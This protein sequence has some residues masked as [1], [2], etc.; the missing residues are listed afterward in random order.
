MRSMPRCVPF[1]RRRSRRSW[2]AGSARPRGRR[3]RG[4]RPGPIA[5]AGA[6]SRWPRSARLWSPWPGG[7][8]GWARHGGGAFSGKDPSKVD[9]SAAYYARYIAKHVVAAKLARRCEV[10]FAY[11]IGV[12]K[13]VSMLVQTFGTG[14]VSDDKLSAAVSRVFDARPGMRLLDI[15]AGWGAMTETA[16]KRG[17]DTTSLTISRR[18]EA[19]VRDLITAQG[20][21]ARVIRE[22]LLEYR[23]DRPYDAIVNLGVSEHLPDYAATLAC[24]ERLLVPGGKIY[25]DACSSRVR[26]RARRGEAAAPR[27]RRSRRNGTRSAWVSP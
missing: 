7:A 8:S 16:G 23:P 22:H 20:L 13:P 5:L 25:L 18:S 14:V 26:A 17:I 11:A 12:A 19:Y 15:G 2:N 10:Q 24:Y 27:G 4:A 1:R 21:P 6:C 9:R 3:W